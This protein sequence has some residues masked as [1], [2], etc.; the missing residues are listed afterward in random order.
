MKHKIQSLLLN[1]PGFQGLCRF[2]T[3]RQPRALMYHRFS[4]EPRDDQ[5][6]VDD[7][8]LRK[9]AALIR[10]HHDVWTPDQHLQQIKGRPESG[11]CPVI[12]TVDDGYLDF[13]DV[14]FPVFREFGIPAMLFVTTGFV[15]G[16]IWFWWDKVEY[17]FSRAEARTIEFDAEGMALTL[18]LE[19]AAGRRAAWNAV[20][21]RCR[22]IPDEKK[23][24]LIDELSRVLEIDLPATPP[25][26]YAAVDWDQLKNMYEN[27]M[28]AGA[29][30][31]HHP[32]LSRI[33]DAQALTEIIES[34]RELSGKLGDPVKWFCYPQGGPADYTQK[35]KETI[36]QH[37]SGCY[38]AYLDI[39]N[40][41]DSYAMPRYCVSRD[42]VHFRW[43][44]CGAEYLGMKLRQL[45]GRPTGAGKFYWTGSSENGEYNA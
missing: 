11:H 19:S 15:S 40:T 7:G 13:H 23:H 6:F 38:L 16:E 20:S 29:H 18:D 21:D 32:I 33:D 10:A 14:A 9:Q 35:I 44:L 26:G 42:M 17:V 1:T 3:R 5:R 24:A 25:P 30:T 41:E 28:L 37:Y 31:V 22:F 39:D 36:A 43:V 34:G 27:G 8:T 45:L 12:V 2:L 4:V